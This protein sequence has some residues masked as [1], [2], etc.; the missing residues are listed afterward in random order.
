MKSYSNQY[1]DR[2]GLDLTALNQEAVSA[3]DECV[4]QLFEYRASTMKQLKAVLEID[5]SMPMAICLQGYL[6]LMIG[7]NAVKDRAD[8]AL[9]DLTAYAGE[10]NPRESLHL[11]ALEYWIEGDDVHACHKW[12]EIIYR[13]PR[14]ILAIR[15]L[16]SSSF[17][18]GNAA[19]LH[20]CTACV[21][22]EWQPG[23]PGYGYILGMYA[24]ALEEFCRRWR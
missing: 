4:N 5:S 15:L 19:M 21:M 8:A 13:Y 9:H 10:L 7:S 6:F 23:D 18:M 20:D 3:Y 16:H 24:F 17:W 2:F 22:L 1:Q 11:A 12:Y 14:D